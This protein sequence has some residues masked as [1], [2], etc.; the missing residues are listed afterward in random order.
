MQ[1]NWTL[2]EALRKFEGTPSLSPDSHNPETASR[3]AGHVGQA[4]SSLVHALL[5]LLFAGATPCSCWPPCHHTSG[6]GYMV[7]ARGGG[8][9]CFP[10]ALRSTLNFEEPVLP[11]GLCF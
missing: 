5:R 6:T 1:L 2:S 8:S 7:R 3:G 9:P 4:I 10:P 11:L